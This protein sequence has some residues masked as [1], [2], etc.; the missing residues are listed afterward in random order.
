MPSRPLPLAF[1][2]GVAA[3]A[4]ASLVAVVV[5]P[6]PAPPAP[7][8]V[9]TATGAAPV[10]TPRPTGVASPAVPPPASPASLPPGSPAFGVGAPAP[11]LDLPTVGGGSISL[12]ALAG[13]PV[14]LVFTATWCPSCREDAALM[15]TLALRYRSTGLV[16]AA[17]H[18]REDAATVAAFS[19][20]PDA[21]YPLALDLDGSAARDWRVVALPSHRFIDASGT[22]RAGVAGSPG[23]EVLASALEEILPGVEVTP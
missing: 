11:A 13:R 8:A 5:G 19:G 22:I 17:I 18:V 6:P 9:A 15:R 10:A 3:V 14:W 4:A 2:A 21:A 12:A 7:T 1:A 23:R 16:I 20:A